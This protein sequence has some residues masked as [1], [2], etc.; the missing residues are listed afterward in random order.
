[1]K[2]NPDPNPISQTHRRIWQQSLVSNN[3]FDTRIVNIM[4]LN[5]W[6]WIHLFDRCL[7]V[8]HTIAVYDVYMWELL[9]RCAFSFIN[10]HIM[11]KCVPTTVW[12]GSPQ[13]DGGT[14]GTTSRGLCMVIYHELKR[15]W[16]QTAVLFVM[17]LLYWHTDGKMGVGEGSASHIYSSKTA[18]PL[19]MREKGRLVKLLVLWVIQK[20]NVMWDD[21]SISCHVGCVTVCD[22]AE[23][24][25]H[26]H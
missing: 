26:N 9:G 17:L 3:F 16:G 23:R 2:N 12:L 1:M 24:Q 25:N 10:K 19:H 4:N 15:P 13:V 11:S 22:K 5:H 8:L 18:R 14:T 20:I 21:T 7:T 6:I